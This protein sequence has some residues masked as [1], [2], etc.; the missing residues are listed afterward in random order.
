M[1]I[2]DALVSVLASREFAIGGGAGL[3]EIVHG[4]LANALAQRLGISLPDGADPMDIED[5]ERLVAGFLD[6]SAQRGDLP[7][8]GIGGLGPGGARKKQREGAGSEPPHEI[9]Q[10]FSGT[11]GRRFL[12]RSLFLDHVQNNTPA[13]AA[14][15]V[16]KSKARAKKITHLWEWN[17]PRNDEK[18]LWNWGS[19]QRGAVWDGGTE[20]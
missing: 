17:P 3:V 2:E 9:E 6:L 10:V 14:S 8:R 1:N 11:H 18:A 12:R 13:P 15:K 16:R 5:V 19:Y 20:K 4:V 7:I